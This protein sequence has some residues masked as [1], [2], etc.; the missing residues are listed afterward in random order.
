VNSRVKE[1]SD[2]FDIYSSQ[3]HVMARIPKGIPDL[4]M[5]VSVFSHCIA[6][7]A[8]LRT[9]AFDERPGLKEFAE[10]VLV[11]TKELEEKYIEAFNN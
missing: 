5:T 6:Y 1:S 7:L 8:V 3:G 10:G 4:A 2:Y 9:Y 11:H